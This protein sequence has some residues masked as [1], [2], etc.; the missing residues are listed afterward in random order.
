MIDRIVSLLLTRNA[1]ERGL[2]G[3]LAVLVLPIAAIFLLVLP[4]LQALDDA[5]Q[6][7]QVAR[8]ENIWVVQ[9]AQKN[10]VKIPSGPTREKIDPLG[11]SGLEEILRNA[12]IHQSVGRMANRDAGAVEITFEQVEF[13]QLAR[14]ISVNQGSW[15]YDIQTYRIDEHIREG[16]VDD[17]FYLEPME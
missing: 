1:R 12:G 16:F 3:V 5:Q 6:D 15:G 14:W 17:E 13:A 2:I 11:L 8:S 4:S 9:Q 10:G 7:I